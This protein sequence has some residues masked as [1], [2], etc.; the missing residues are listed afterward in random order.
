[1]NEAQRFNQGHNC[2]FEHDLELFREYLKAL[3]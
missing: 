3:L 1:M 2:M